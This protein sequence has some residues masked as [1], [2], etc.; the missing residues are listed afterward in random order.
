[1]AVAPPAMISGSGVPPLEKSG[2]EP[3]P[4]ASAVTVTGSVERLRSTATAVALKSVGTWPKSTEGGSATSAVS[5]PSP[6][7]VTSRSPQPLQGVTARAARFT[8][9]RWGWKLT[10]WVRVSPGDRV[11]EAI[12][13]SSPPAPTMRP[14]TVQREGGS[15]W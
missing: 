8:P 3:G 12:E 6:V 2:S 10:S 14:L 13:N 1:M 4:K 9:A 15:C 11:S 7:S 5:S